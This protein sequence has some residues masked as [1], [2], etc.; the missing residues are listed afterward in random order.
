[1]DLQ[2]TLEQTFATN[3]QVYF[4]T[5]SAHVNIVGRNF[6]SDHKLLQKIY[7]GLQ[8]D[9]D[10]LGELL[11]T[12]QAFFPRSLNEVVN[13]SAASD[14]SMQGTSLEL[15]E[16]VYDDIDIL[17]DQY[18]ELYSAAEDEGHIEISNFAQDQIRVMRK[19]CW[20]LRSILENDHGADS[21]TFYDND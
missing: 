4:R 14:S 2:S 15:L 19:T 3:F 17:I 10:T 1:M 20:M 21:D 9:I 11:R 13:N 16:S 6:Y 7:E 18:T 12:I 8:G 5:H